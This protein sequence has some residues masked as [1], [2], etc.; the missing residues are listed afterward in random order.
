LKTKTIKPI[1]KYWPLFWTG[2]PAITLRPWIFV[3]KDLIMKRGMPWLRNLI[4]RH[5]VHLEQQSGRSRLKWI[6]TYAL[7][8]KRRREW[9]KIALDWQWLDHEK[10]GLKI[11]STRKELFG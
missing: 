6:L 10:K 1:S 11:Y 2:S 8:K 3:R 9:L 5:Y 7:F 4:E